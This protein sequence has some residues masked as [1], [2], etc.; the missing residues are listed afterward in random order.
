MDIEEVNISRETPGAGAIPRSGDESSWVEREGFD[1]YFK[2]VTQ[3]LSSEIKSE[4]RSFA[5]EQL[6]FLSNKLNDLAQVLRETAA[7][8]RE[9]RSNLLADLAETGSEGM[10]RIS[11]DIRDE[12]TERIVAR[13]ES[14]ARNRP[15][16]FM[17]AAFAA[18]IVIWQLSSP[19]KRKTMIGESDRE[20]L[21]MV[22]DAAQEE[23]HDWQH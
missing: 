22:E 23:H 21:P 3:T 19:E 1:E 20:H 8:L 4:S 17:T 6:H 5:V 9:K 14:F 2:K 11:G 12:Y 18:G 16:I 15:G 7:R 13:V 10:E